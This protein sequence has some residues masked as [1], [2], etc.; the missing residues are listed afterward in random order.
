[1]P[2]KNR[3]TKHKIP[4]GGDCEYCGG[5]GKIERIEPLMIEKFNLKGK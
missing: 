4:N 5:T 1:M 2:L 3:L